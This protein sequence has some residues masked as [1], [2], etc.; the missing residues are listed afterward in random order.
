LKTL[1]SSP[2]DLKISEFKVRRK[3]GGRK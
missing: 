2:S 1:P 3:I